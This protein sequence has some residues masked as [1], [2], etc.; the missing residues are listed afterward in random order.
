MT[1]V[2]SDNAGVMVR[3]ATRI[4]H[5]G[6]LQVKIGSAV[7][8]GRA[9]VVTIEDAAKMNEDERRKA[10]GRAAAGAALRM[11]ELFGDDFDPSEIIR[12]A[13]DAL[14]KLM[15]TARP[16]AA[17]GLFTTYEPVALDGEGKKTSEVAKRA[18]ED[19]PLTKA[20]LSGKD[21]SDLA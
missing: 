5:T 1:R 18:S 9:T 10:V 19:D 15:A 21:I 12:K 2:T 7:K 8:P 6:K 13:D 16:V 20:H 14:H 17:I 11:N 3:I 4:P